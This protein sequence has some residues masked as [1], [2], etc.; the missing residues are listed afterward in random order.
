ML[1]GKIAL[2]T[3][4]SKGIGAGIAKELAARG[5]AVAV[6]YAS[7]REGAD[8]V[9]NEIKANGGRAAAFQG[10][11]SNHAAV[12]RIFSE[13]GAAFGRIGIL[14]N[15]A[16]VFRLGSL[17]TVTEQEFHDHFNINVLGLLLTTQ[18]AAAQ[19]GDEGGSIINIGSIISQIPRP[20]TVLYAASKGAMDA[21]TKVLALE[22]GPKK[23]RINSVLPGPTETE[24]ANVARSKGDMDEAFVRAIID[25]TALGRMGTSEDIALAVAFLASDDARWITGQLISVSGGRH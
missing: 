21:V 11:I 19:F 7:S 6:N 25:R 3:G 16:G 4:A 13:V 14:V 15:N 18:N 9:V 5:A 17:E 1:T 23:I 10:D 2:V 12:E 22:L 24:G 8:R 20:G